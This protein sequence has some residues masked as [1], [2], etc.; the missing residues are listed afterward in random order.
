MDKN[1]LNELLD[2]LAQ[3]KDNQENEALS[4]MDRPSMGMP[5]TKKLKKDN[6]GIP[7]DDIK[8]I[9]DNI[10]D[11]YVDSVGNMAMGSASA[12]KIGSKLEQ[13]LSKRLPDT[14][15]FRQ[16]LDTQLGRKLRE[17]F[18]QQKNLDLV[19]KA[20][21]ENMRISE[22]QKALEN[23]AIN[24]AK[25]FDEFTNAL[26]RKSVDN[27]MELQEYNRQQEAL[28]QYMKSSGLPQGQFDQTVKI[29]EDTVSKKKKAN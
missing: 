27:A 2:Y 22:K 19:D 12:L 23:M 8:N 9:R 4:L 5:L 3:N 7:E 24:P 6:P 25:E 21:L 17:P 10:R 18:I 16:L 15:R 20:N 1:Y 29:I 11:D 14:S 28:K 13:E 26:K